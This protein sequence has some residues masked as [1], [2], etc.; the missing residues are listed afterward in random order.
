MDLV[1]LN[2]RCLITAKYHF[3]YPFPSTSDRCH[4]FT[5]FSLNAKPLPLPLTNDLAVFPQ[6]LGHEGPIFRCWLEPTVSSMA[7][8]NFLRQAL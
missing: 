8:L 2:S 6:R 4:N 3:F 1:L 7:A 5:P